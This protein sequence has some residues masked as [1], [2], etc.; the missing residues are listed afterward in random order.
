MSFVCRCGL[1]SGNKNS[2]LSACVHIDYSSCFDFRDGTG[3]TSVWCSASP[4][5]EAGTDVICRSQ[6]AHIELPTNAVLQVAE[7]R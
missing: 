4:A 5:P 1:S 3:T 7:V 6:V 2:M